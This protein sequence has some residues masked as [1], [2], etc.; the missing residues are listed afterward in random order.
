MRRQKKRCVCAG[1][2]LVSVPSGVKSGADVIG[3]A[4]TK[5]RWIGA[6]ER[7]ELVRGCRRHCGCACAVY[8]VAVAATDLFTRLAQ[9]DPGCLSVSKCT[10]N[11][12]TCTTD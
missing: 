9:A 10:L 11:G 7:G 3:Y 6:T 4:R 12:R 1:R 5:R 2:L 8:T